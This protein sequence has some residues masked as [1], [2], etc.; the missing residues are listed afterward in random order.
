MSRMNSGWT[1]S[2]YEI[3]ILQSE[4]RSAVEYRGRTQPVRLTVRL[5]L[6]SATC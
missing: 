1:D 2:R 3:Y 5:T 6:N 4:V